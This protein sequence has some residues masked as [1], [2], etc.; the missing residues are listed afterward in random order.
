MSFNFFKIREDSDG[1]CRVSFQNPFITFDGFLKL[2]DCHD[3]D[4]ELVVHNFNELSFYRAWAS[5]VMRDARLR[6]LKKKQCFVFV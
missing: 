6:F 5:D 2:Y 4:N 3:A 1:P